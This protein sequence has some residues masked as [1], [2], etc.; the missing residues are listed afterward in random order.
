MN[1]LVALE[2]KSGESL[3]SCGSSSWHKMSTHPVVVDFDPLV[4]LDERNLRITKSNWDSSCGHHE[5]LHLISSPPMQK[6]Y[7]CIYI[8]HYTT[9]PPKSVGFILRLSV[10]HC[11]ISLQIFQFGPKVKQLTTTFPSLKP[12]SWCAYF[13]R[14][15]QR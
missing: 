1:L 10:E 5:Y 2:E 9:K 14:S 3:Y 11:I 15:Y 4:E 7:R 12:L 8:I 13:A 6:L